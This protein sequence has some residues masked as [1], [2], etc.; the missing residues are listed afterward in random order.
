MDEIT[1]RMDD[2]T[3]AIR[4]HRQPTTSPDRRFS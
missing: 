3:A 2:L 1:Q 4:E